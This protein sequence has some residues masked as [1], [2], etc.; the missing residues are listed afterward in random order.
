[1]EDIKC[2]LAHPKDITKI[3][4]QKAIHRNFRK[5]IKTRLGF[6]IISGKCYKKGGF[7]KKRGLLSK[8]EAR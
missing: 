4:L 2:E 7:Y 5:K 6:F 1:M 3:C 8:T